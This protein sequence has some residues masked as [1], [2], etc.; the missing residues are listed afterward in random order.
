MDRT[1]VTLIQVLELLPGLLL[2]N[3]GEE[4]PQGL[5]FDGQNPVDQTGD[6]V[7]SCALV[8]STTG[9]P[10]NLPFREDQNHLYILQ[11]RVDGGGAKGRSPG[12]EGG[13]N[14]TP[15]SLPRST[16]I[17]FHTRPSVMGL[18]VSE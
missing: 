9:F 12:E 16:D 8:S 11:T 6:R 17:P 15:H 1:P 7:P 4:S 5:S 2:V 14:I 3:R 10:G 13:T 18:W